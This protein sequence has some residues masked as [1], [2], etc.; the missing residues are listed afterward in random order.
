MIKILG[1]LGTI[2]LG[3]L[4]LG[5]AYGVILVILNTALE[6]FNKATNYWLDIKSRNQQ[7]KLDSVR[8]LMPD[9]NTRQGV[10]FDGSDY[11]NLDTGQVFS[12]LEEKYFDPL[13]WKIDKVQ[14]TLIAMKGVNFPQEKVEQLIAPSQEVLLPSRVT[15]EEAIQ[16]QRI[17]LDNLVLGMTIENGVIKPVTRSLHDLLH[18]CNIGRSGA[19]KSCW[20]LSFLA[21]IEMC[22]EPIEVCLIDIHGSAFNVLSNWGKLRYPIARTNDQAKAI[23]EKVKAESER[24]M[25]LYQKLPLADSMQSYNQH[26]KLDK[27][28]PWLVVIDEG[29]LMLADKSISRYVAAAVQGT[30]QYGLYIFLSGQTAKAS[31]ITTPIRDNFPTRIC[32]NNEESSIRVVLGGSPPG[33]LEQIPGRGWARL[34]GAGKPIKIQAP[35]INRSTLYRMISNDGPKEDFPIISGECELIESSS[36][37]QRVRELGRLGY[38]RRQIEKEVFG[39]VGGSA[40]EKVKKIL[41]EGNEI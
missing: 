4:C 19:G 18:L 14:Q 15:L 20:N 30:R 7:I 9:E 34:K 28:V 1:I 21:E 26:T 35:I 33:E 10:V 3:T 23:L 16:G 38:S 11:R 37:E 24:R 41:E 2:I 32:F 29:T 6:W 40:F 13:M 31:V 5:G 12:M 39:H 8:R 22:K 17:S 25:E 27:L 36:E